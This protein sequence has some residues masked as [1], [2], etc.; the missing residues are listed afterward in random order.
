MLIAS[1]WA[2]RARP[3]QRR[4]GGQ[5]G[6]HD[7]GRS[8]AT[9]FAGVK[10]EIIHTFNLAQQR[11]AQLLVAASSFTLPALEPRC[12]RAIRLYRSRPAN[13]TISASKLPGL[14]EPSAQRNVD[15][16]AKDRFMKACSAAI[17]TLSKPEATLRL[18][19]TTAWTSSS[20]AT[21]PAALGCVYSIG[22]INQEN[23]GALTAKIAELLKPFGVPDNRMYLNFFDAACELWLSSKTFAE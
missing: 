19:S 15:L 8:T 21:T 7:H 1:L 9:F 5:R 14:S 11:N 4:R 2:R 22:Q 13:P 6:G 20:A 12:V 10:G 3:Q 23:N 17:A 18:A 16:G